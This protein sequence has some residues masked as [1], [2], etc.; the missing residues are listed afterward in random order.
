MKN[1][2]YEDLS[3]TYKPAIDAQSEIKKSIDEEQN[4]IIKPKSIKK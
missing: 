4:E 3:E 1:N 2:V